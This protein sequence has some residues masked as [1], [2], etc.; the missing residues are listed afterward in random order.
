ML[1]A[2][3]IFIVFLFLI[4]LSIYNSSEESPVSSYA[5]ISDS[6]CVPADCCHST[7]CISASEAPSCDGV[8]CTQECRPGTLDCGQGF[9]SCIKG[10]CKAISND[11]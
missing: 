10:E 3:I 9:C 6:D 2:L 1:F 4:F 11:E 8:Y 7:S 5:C